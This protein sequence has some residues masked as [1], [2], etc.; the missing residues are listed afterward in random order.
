MAYIGT[1]APAGWLLCDGSAINRTAYATLFSVINTNCGAGNGSTTFNLPDLWGRFR[2]G[3]DSGTGRD[4]DAA[5]RIA[6][7]AGSNSGNAIGSIQGFATSAS[8]LAT[9]GA[10]G[11]GHTYPSSF[12][13][14]QGGTA[15]HANIYRTDQGNP[16]N[17]GTSTEPDHTHSLSGAN[18]T[19]PLNACVNYIIKYYTSRDPQNNEASYEI[20]GLPSRW[21][22]S[23]GWVGATVLGELVQSGGRWWDQRRWRVHG[24]RHLRPA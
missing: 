12:S 8:G 4:L 1:T 13:G 22:H 19:C 14:F 3:V 20:L 16:I 11:H 21:I 17:Q 6:M 18:E 24:E 7:N 10:G 9:V 2:R 5:S 23:D 15:G